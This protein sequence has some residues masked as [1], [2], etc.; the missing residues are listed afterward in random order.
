MARDLKADQALLSEILAH[1][2]RRDFVRAATLAEQALASGFEHPMLL[3]VVATRREQEGR[4]EESLG[5]LEQALRISPGDVGA[6]NALALCLQRLDRPAE[7]LAHL[8]RLLGQHPDLGFAHANRGNALIALGSL[9]RAKQSHLRALEL[10]PGNLA[11]S[12]ALASIA[13][14]RGEHDDARRW[15]EQ[16]LA[17]LPGLPDAVLSLAAA[18]LAA[19]ATARAETLLW[20]LL[21]DARAGQTDKARASGLLGDVLD[22]AGR[23]AEAFDAYAA[24][25][26]LLQQVHRRFASGPSVLA[27]ARSLAAAMHAAGPGPWAAGAAGSAAGEAAGHVFLIGFPRSGTTLLEA[28]LDGHPRI[29]SIEEH[30]LLIDSVLRFAGEP[31][32]LAPLAHATDAE[33]EPF[34]AAYWRRVREAGFD[35]AG[36]VFIDKYPLNTLKLPL[37]ARLFPCAK[38][39]FACRDPRDVVLGCF[40]RRFKMNPAMYELL[41]LPGAAALYDAVIGFAEQARPLLGLDWQVVR[42]ESLVADLDEQTRVVCAFLGLKTVAG[43]EDFAARVQSREHA[44]P[45]TAQLARGLD[46]SGIGHWRHYAAQLEPVLPSLRPWVESLRYPD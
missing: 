45:S 33:L 17:A 31:L 4:L 1:T 37:I 12:A 41:S 39:L 15:A 30:E 19:G 8:D 7:A 14:Q 38:V 34:R 11:A 29:V 42:Y 32:D 6:R 40:R 5:L 3:N 43:M 13:T 36:K 16:A 27:Y 9:G 28:V 25:N 24:C 10:D 21:A 44:T 20:K 26:G 46:R 22:A 35:V 2:E 18:E 23:Y